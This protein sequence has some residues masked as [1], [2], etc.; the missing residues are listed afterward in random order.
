MKRAVIIAVI[1]VLA[2]FFLVQ[3]PFLLSSIRFQLLTRK[4]EAQI[5]RDQDPEK[6]RAWAK[7]LLESHNK[8]TIDSSSNLTNF[9]PIKVGIHHEYT[10]IYYAEAETDGKVKLNPSDRLRRSS[11]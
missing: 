9:T 11:M 3:S 4:W 6:L 10:S 7:E 2:L 8:K 5:K 1:T